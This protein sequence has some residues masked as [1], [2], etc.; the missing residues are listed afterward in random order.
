MKTISVP[1]NTSFTVGDMHYMEDYVMEYMDSSV[2]EQAL[3][4]IPENEVPFAYYDFIVNEYLKE[5]I[6]RGR[7]LSEDLPQTASNTV[8]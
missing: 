3:E 2:V 5:S 8:F 7:Q 6:S 1:I 4:G